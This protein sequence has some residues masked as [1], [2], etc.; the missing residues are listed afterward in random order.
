MEIILWDDLDLSS[1][2]Q[3]GYHR[4]FIPSLSDCKVGYLMAKAERGTL[5]D[6]TKATKNSQEIKRKYG[7][8]HFYMDDEIPFLLSMPDAVWSRV[9]AQAKNT[10][11]QLQFPHAHV[12]H[13][14]FFKSPTVVVQKMKAAEESSLV[15]HCADSK[16]TRAQL[17]RFVSDVKANMG[18]ASEFA[19]NI[20]E[21]RYRLYMMVLDSPGLGTDLQALVSTNGE[22]FYI[23]LG[24]HAT[25]TPLDRRILGAKGGEVCGESFDAIIEALDNHAVVVDTNK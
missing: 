18:D 1:T 6:M 21:E 19:S 24:G 13:T 4:C 16:Y 7:A 5:D 9:N 20:A 11:G 3:C 17:P 8:K 12:N 15:L 22:L 14:S 25:C 23:D 2:V 10:L